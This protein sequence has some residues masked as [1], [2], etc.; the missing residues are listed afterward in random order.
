MAKMVEVSGGKDIGLS[1][2]TNGTGKEDISSKKAIAQRNLKIKEGS[3]SIS[4]TNKNA[5]VVYVR[6]LNSGVLPFGQELAEKRN[7]SVVTNYTD[8]QGNPINITS[9]SQGTDFKATV[10]ITNLKSEQVNDVALTEIFPSGWEITNTRFTDYGNSTVSNAS[11]TDIRDDR[12]NFYFDL[13]SRETKTFTVLLNASYL[14]KYYL[15]G[16]QAEA[17]YDNDYF[18]RNKGQW[19]EVVK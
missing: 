19:I 1:F 17:M 2:T 14:G 11:F 4:V 10:T 3:N 9:L 5:N 13:N 15:P 8:L 12:V 16:L 18:V 7:L 6:V